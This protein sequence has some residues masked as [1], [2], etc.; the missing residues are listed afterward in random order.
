MSGDEELVGTDRSVCATEEEMLI[1]SREVDL[2]EKFAAIE[3]SF[4]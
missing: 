1:A 4:A 2:V 3:P